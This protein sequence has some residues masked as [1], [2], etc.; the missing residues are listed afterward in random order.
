MSHPNVRIPPDST[1][2]RIGTSITLEVSYTGLS[3]DLEIGDLITCSTSGVVGRV[4][5]V[6]PSSATAG[7]MH[8]LLGH[9]FGTDALV[10]G[11]TFTADGQTPQGTGTIGDVGTPIHSARNISVGNN[12]HLYGQHIDAQGASSVKFPDGAPTLAAFGT[13]MTSEASMVGVYDFSAGTSEDLFA[14]ITGSA[15]TASYQPVSSTFTLAVDSASGSYVEATTNKY[16]F[17]WPGHGL[18][19][20]MTIACS[21]TGVSGNVRRWGMFDDNDGIFF[22]L[23]GSMINV[24]LRS[25]TSGVVVEERFAQTDWNIDKLDGTGLSQKIL[26]VDKI[27]PY[28][29]DYQ[30]LG[31]GKIRFGIIGADGSKIYCHGVENAGNRNLPYMAKGSLPIRVD[32]WNYIAHGASPNIRLTCASVTNEGKIDYT[33]WRYVYDH[34]TVAVAGN[35]VPLISVRSKVTYSGKHNQTNVYPES[36]NCYIRGGIVKLEFWWPIDLVNDTWS[37]DNGSTIECDTAATS[38]AIGD[39]SEFMYSTFL[40]EGCHEINLSRFFEVNDEGIIT[41]S[42]GSYSYPYS[43]VATLVS[44]SSADIDGTITYKE[45]R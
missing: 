41:N 5:E 9:D 30:W 11:E 40:G 24:V 22:E 37:N 6:I 14:V 26:N 38:T 3:G 13:L 35:Q 2:K 16:H 42:K 12:N 44:G 31:A 32:N 1:G 19:G 43:I 4:S 36:Y 7:E 27:L 18:T 8:I 39:D 34:G 21:D 17:Y 10:A 23:S 45:L 28:F 20:L 29:M 33:F 25:S 15:G